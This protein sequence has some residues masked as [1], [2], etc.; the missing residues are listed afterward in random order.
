[1]TDAPPVSNLARYG[2]LLEKPLFF[3]IALF[4]FASASTALTGLMNSSFYLAVILWTGWLLCMRPVLPWRS[5]IF[6]LFMLLVLVFVA[7]LLL[8]GDW[9]VNNLNEFKKDYLK[10]L[11]VFLMACSFIRREQQAR[12]ILLGFALGFALRSLLLL[13]YYGLD[14]A[15]LAPYRRGYAMDAV[16]YLPLTSVLLLFGQDWLSRRWRVLLAVMWGVEML[17]LVLHQSRTPL[18]AIIASLLLLLLLNGSWRKSLLLLLGC[19]ISA[20][21]LFAA[22]PELWQRY[23]ST[24]RSDTYQQDPA[25]LERQGIWVATGYLI[26]Q[27]PVLGYGPGWRKLALLVRNKPLLKYLQAGSHPRNRSG[28]LYFTKRGYPYGKANPHSLYLQV[29]LETGLCGLLVYLSFLLTILWLSFRQVWRKTVRHPVAGSLL[30][31]IPAFL[32]VG[33]ANGM[34]AN[35]VLLMMLAGMLLVPQAAPRSGSSSGK[36]A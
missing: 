21:G 34:W 19:V 4:C 10:P 32:L 31:I 6:R 5:G 1:M 20:A 9:L 11:L 8:N 18:L 3:L 14:L 36:L 35:A 33:F 24:F 16:F 25:L 13:A 23:A 29:A 22:K 27:Q 26:R 15:W 7:S 2:A 30:V 17:N 12:I 28:Y